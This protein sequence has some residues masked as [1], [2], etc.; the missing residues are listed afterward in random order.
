MADSHG[1]FAIGSEMSGGV[2]DVRATNCNFIGSGRGFHIKSCRGR[3]G[4]VRNIYVEGFS[5]SRVTNSAISVDLSYQ[6]KYGDGSENIQADETTP[7]ISDI[8]V[9][10]VFSQASD[11]PISICGLPEMPVKNYVIENATLDASRPGSAR[12]VE[13]L[14]LRGV[15]IDAPGCAEFDSSKGDSDAMTFEYASGLVLE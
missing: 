10:N 8:F 14:V 7:V 11:S 15:R 1:G 12:Y 5:M 3:G 9:K 4:Y 13:G 2:E 6:T